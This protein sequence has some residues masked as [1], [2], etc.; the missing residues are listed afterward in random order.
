MPRSLITGP[1]AEPLTTAAAKSHLRV[2]VTDDDTLI[3]S[4]VVAARQYCEN[5]LRRALI[6]QTWDVYFDTFPARIKVPLPR[7]QSVTSIKYTD[8][9]GV[10]T[11]LAASKYKVDVISEP[12]RIDPAYGE[13]WPSTRAEMN[14][15]VVQFKAG[16]GDASTDIPDT[17]LEAHKLLIGHW[18]E[19]REAVL[20]G[21]G[22]V[23]VPLAVEALLSGERVLEF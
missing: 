5:H 22:A 12:G 10:T 2:D 9:E 6:T 16:Y 4:L 1:S 13:V 7:L 17:V 15:V 11:T 19:H 14:A 21:V 8:T 20:V 18:Y 23:R 3:D